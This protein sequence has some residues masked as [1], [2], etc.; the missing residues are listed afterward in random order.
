MTGWPEGEHLTIGLW[1]DRPVSPSG[2]VAVGNVLEAEGGRYGG[3][4]FTGP[5]GIA[6]AWMHDVE[7]FE[8]G[9]DWSAEQVRKVMLKGTVYR[10][11][12]DLPGLG[13]AR[14]EVEG[15][16]EEAVPEQHPV[17]LAV[18]ADVLAFVR[19]SRDDEERAAAALLEPHVLRYLKAL[20][21]ELDPAY[22]MLYA[23]GAIK[24]WTPAVLAGGEE[25]LGGDFFVSRRFAVRPP[26]DAQLAEVARLAGATLEW[27]TG[28]FYSG[29][30]YVLPD[31]PDWAVLMA[32]CAQVSQTLG[33]LL[34]VGDQ[35]R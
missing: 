25:A 19:E 15:T 23:E 35:G 11:N 13:A 26:L 12:M 33:Q 14:L 32:A 20:C 18:G 5:A 2:L 6:F 34:T 7:G 10:V 8:R 27:E 21:T 16:S 28:T 9:T 17:R 4:V 1:F 29:T 3:Q 22:A 30:G 24:T 31:A